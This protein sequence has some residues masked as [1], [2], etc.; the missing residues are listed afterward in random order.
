[1]QRSALNLIKLLLVEEVY[2]IEI[3][4]TN[5]KDSKLTAE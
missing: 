5:E 4:S 3:A 1:M 2:A